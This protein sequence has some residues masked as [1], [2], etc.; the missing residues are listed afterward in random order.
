VN[1]LGKKAWISL[2]LW[3]LA[4]VA[5]TFGSVAL[6]QAGIIHISNDFGGL[7]PVFIV[8]GVCLFLA[9]VSWITNI[10]FFYIDYRRR[11]ITG[12]TP[13]GY[14]SL[15]WLIILGPVVSVSFFLLV[16]FV[17]VRVFNIL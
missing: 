14:Q 15:R 13:K 17:V 12:I 6:Y 7:I 16:Y 5:P 2:I 1:R 9:I 10:I 11:K 4:L 3:C 8:F